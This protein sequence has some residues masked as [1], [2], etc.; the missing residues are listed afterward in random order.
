[1]DQINHCQEFLLQNFFED[2]PEGSF[3]NPVIVEDNEDEEV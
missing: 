1:M 3:A 2:Q